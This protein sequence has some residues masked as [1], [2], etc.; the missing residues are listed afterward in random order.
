MPQ[1]FSIHTPIILFLLQCDLKRIFGISHFQG[2]KMIAN[3]IVERARVRA[4]TKNTSASSS[5]VADIVQFF[6]RTVLLLCYIV[7]VFCLVD[8][9]SIVPC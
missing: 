6:A 7:A 4:R 1:P 8:H 9:L 3:M 5:L 2:R